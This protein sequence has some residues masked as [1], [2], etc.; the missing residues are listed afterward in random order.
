M[1]GQVTGLI[2]LCLTK[3]LSGTK[4]PSLIQKEPLAY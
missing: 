3:L 4:T 2:K 1:Q